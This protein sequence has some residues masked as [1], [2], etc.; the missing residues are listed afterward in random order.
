MVNKAELTNKEISRGGLIKVFGD[1]LLWSWLNPR[2]AKLAIINKH[3]RQAAIASINACFRPRFRKC[4]ILNPNTPAII[5][6]FTIVWAELL[7]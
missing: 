7:M 5:P 3:P 6:V 1:I 4:P 2:Y